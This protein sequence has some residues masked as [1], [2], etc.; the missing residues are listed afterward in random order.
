MASGKPSDL[1]GIALYVLACIERDKPRIYGKNLDRIIQAGLT[2]VAPDVRKAAFAAAREKPTLTEAEFTALILG[3]R[4][5]DADAANSAFA[6]IA[7]K[8]GL[9]L[10]RPQWRLLIHSVQLA[11]QSRSVKLPRA[12]AYTCSQLMSLVPAG[13]ME[14]SLS[15][16][17][18]IFL[19]DPCFS[20]RQNAVMPE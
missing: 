8:K 10:K 13:A 15:D 6:A 9:E 12:A 16:L 11:A 3:T 1:R 17:L 14:K 4:D 7:N 19:R 18:D 2:D 20:V 5:G